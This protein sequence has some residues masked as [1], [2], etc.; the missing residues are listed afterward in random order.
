MEKSIIQK[1]RLE[2]GL[3][4]RVI[5]KAMG[6]GFS[7]AR[8]SNM[9]RGLTNLSAGDQAAI[10]EAIERLAPLDRHRRRIAQIVR[11]MDFAPLVAD[12]HEARQAAVEA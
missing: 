5:A 6:P 12:V 8:L 2:A 10:L 1:R 9:E 11:D 3:T 7:P 4:L